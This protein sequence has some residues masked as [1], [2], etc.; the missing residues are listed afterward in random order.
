[1]GQLTKNYAVL[2]NLSL[3]DYSS[4][5]LSNP[6]SPIARAYYKGDQLNY[7]SFMGHIYKVHF[8]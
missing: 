6:L 8:E 5:H 4:H 1:M 7:D 2:D 3:L